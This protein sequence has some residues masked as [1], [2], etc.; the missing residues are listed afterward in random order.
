M[1]SMKTLFIRIMPFIAAIAAGAALYIF[2]AHYIKNSGLNDLMVNI[3]AGLLSIP[4]VFI[5]YEIFNERSTRDLKN[6]LR[7]H[8]LFEINDTIITV[9]NAMRS[10]LAQTGVLTRE[11]LDVFLN[12]D[13][14]QI[15]KNLILNDEAANILHDAKDKLIR[16]IGNNNNSAVFSNTEIEI[17]F[18]VSNALSVIS[19]EIKY[20]SKIKDEKTLVSTIEKLLKQIDSWTDI[21]EDDIVNHHSF[22]II[23]QN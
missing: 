19:K 1:R 15:H 17:I 7:E 9:I 20:R 23:S 2:S 11:E 18:A 22:N 3:A 5:S 21:Y 13:A 10:L 6:A 8:L 4:L 12:M 14:A 16:L